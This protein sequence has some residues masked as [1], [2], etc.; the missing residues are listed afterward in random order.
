MCDMGFIAGNLQGKVK[1]SHLSQM[2]HDFNLDVIDRF[3]KG[4]QVEPTVGDRNL[5]REFK[6][7]KFHAPHKFT[8]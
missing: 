8:F 4:E 7:L 3:L 6:P 1:N 2:M 5:G